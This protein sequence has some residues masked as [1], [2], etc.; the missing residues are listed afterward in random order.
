MTVAFIPARGGSKGLLKK[1]I[2]IFNNKPLLYWSI[3]AASK[4]KKI[5][6]IVISTDDTEIMEIVKSLDFNVVIDQ[7]PINLA[8]DEAKTIDVLNEFAIRNPI[9]DSYVLLQPTSPLRKDGII[10]ECIQ[11]FNNA[12]QDV[13]V[14][15]YLTHIA[16]YG[17]HQNVRRQE[18]KEFFYDDGNI[19]I[20][21]KDIILKNKWYTE[22]HIKY[23]NK[24]PYCMEIDDINEFKI[25][26]ILMKNKH[27][28]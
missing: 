12:N 1:N 2:K 25:L 14:S 24:F 9:Y 20:L 11:I 23:I 8:T 6:D 22:K 26:E 13:L 3:L 15:G 10:D 7:R 27:E 19:Y 4:S 18:L 21:S 5:D 17:T 28:L 16:E